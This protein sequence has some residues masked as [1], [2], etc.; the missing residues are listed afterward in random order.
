MDNHTRFD[1]LQIIARMMSPILE[2]VFGLEKVTKLF[3]SI[4]A[5]KSGQR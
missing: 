4:V 1:A 3:G 5:L 2:Y